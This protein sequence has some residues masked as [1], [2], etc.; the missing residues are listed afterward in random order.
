MKKLI[1][2]E[3]PSWKTLAGILAL[4][5]YLLLIIFGKKMRYA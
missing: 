3:G 4:G 1:Y 5:I 2:S